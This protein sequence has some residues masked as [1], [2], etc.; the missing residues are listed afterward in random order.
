M[1][2]FIL[3][4]A[5]RGWD[6]LDLSNPRTCAANCL[7]ALVKGLPAEKVRAVLVEPD[8]LLHVFPDCMSSYHVGNTR[9]CVYKKL[10][11]AVVMFSPEMWWAT[12]RGSPF[13]W[14]KSAWVTDIEFA[15]S[16]SGFYVRR[17]NCG[18]N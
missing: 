11:I 5:F 9:A 3:W 12:P 14:P 7:T 15:A 1:S 2:L 18:E 17:R 10:G 13:F 4:V 16:P 8:C 6:F